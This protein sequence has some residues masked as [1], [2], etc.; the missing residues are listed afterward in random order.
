MNELLFRKKSLFFSAPAIREI[1]KTCRNTHFQILFENLF[2][3]NFL[4]KGCIS[5]HKNLLTSCQLMYSK[6]CDTRSADM[7]F[8][9]KVIWVL[10]SCWV[11]TPNINA[12]GWDSLLFQSNLLSTVTVTLND[13]ECVNRSASLQQFRLKFTFFRWC[14]CSCYRNMVCRSSG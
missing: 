11:E 1:L 4:K 5:I 6:C 7:S 10:G 8:Q 14:T 13:S 12:S 2:L 9:N 3:L